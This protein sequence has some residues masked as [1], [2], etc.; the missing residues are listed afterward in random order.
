MFFKISFRSLVLV[1]LIFMDEFD[2]ICSSTVDANGTSCAENYELC[3]LF[4]M[5]APSKESWT[6]AIISGALQIVKRVAFD[7]GWFI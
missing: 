3:N 7:W 4:V 1:A 5:E 2:Y 6:G